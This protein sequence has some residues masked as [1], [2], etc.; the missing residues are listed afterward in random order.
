MKYHIK[1][2]LMATDFTSCANNA[3]KVAIAIA[4][5]QNAKLALIH[6]ISPVYIGRPFGLNT[7]Y[8]AAQENQ[9][10]Q[11]YEVIN[12]IKKEILREC[13][14][15]KIS[16]YVTFG[17][18][19]L[20]VTE[21]EIKE[22]I[23]LIVVGKT[24]ATENDIVLIGS[25]AYSIIKKAKCPVLTIPESFKKSN[26]KSVLYPIRKSPGMVE[27]FEYIRPI[28]EKNNSNIHLLGIVESLDKEELRTIENKMKEVFLVM[29]EIKGEISYASTFGQKLADEIV[30]FA[31]E[32]MDDL[33]VLNATLEK[34]WY[35]FFTG[36]FTQKIIANAH[37]PVLT[38]KPE[39]TLETIKI[40]EQQILSD[41]KNYKPFSM[42]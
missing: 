7:I 40:A 11:A 12:Q 16:T 2:I 22:N 14:Q 18:I 5:R 19:S 13:Q 27:K 23:D 31:N 3:L 4:V 36:T 21:Y 17:S 26:F 32:R 39:I 20:V 25:N 28:V 24:G 1:K 6:V 29:N 10:A 34:N 15:L 37:I 42:K 8:S 30:K 38:L 9:I 33:L 35:Q 41:T